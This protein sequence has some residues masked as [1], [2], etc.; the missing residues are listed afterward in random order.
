MIPEIPPLRSISWQPSF[1][2]AASELESDPR[3][4]DPIMQ[5][6]E[7]AV[8]RLS[9]GTPSEGLHVTKL[10]P[11]GDLPPLRVFWRTASNELLEVWWVEEDPSQDDDEDS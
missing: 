9:D 6:I 11:F 8:Q 3:R 7:W 10:F 2:R 1:E 5:A 4:V